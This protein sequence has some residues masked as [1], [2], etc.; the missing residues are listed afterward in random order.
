ML[1]FKLNNELTNI[2]LTICSKK[3]ELNTISRNE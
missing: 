2:Q 1:L 3:V